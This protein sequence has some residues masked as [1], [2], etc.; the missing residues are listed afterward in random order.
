MLNNT[1]GNL[2]HSADVPP[3]STKGR[4]VK[5]PNGAAPGLRLPMLRMK[6][7]TL[8]E[9]VAINCNTSSSQSGLNSMHASAASA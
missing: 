2:A 3:A 9:L 7:S 8:W 5:Y 6:S 4:C 1:E